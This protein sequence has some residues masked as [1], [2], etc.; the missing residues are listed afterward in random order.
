[1]SP[2]SRLAPLLIAFVLSG[3]ALS[4]DGDDEVEPPRRTITNSVGMKF[5]LIRK[6][7]FDMGSAKDDRNGRDDEKPQHKVEITKSFYLGVY[8]V[9]QKQYTQ[10]MGKNP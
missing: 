7:S 9:T 3:V 6:G 5:V 1:M 2:L 10:V 8:E 4:R